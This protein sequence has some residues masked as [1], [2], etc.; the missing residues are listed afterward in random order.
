MKT[1]KTDYK[2]IDIERENRTTDNPIYW[3]KG[4]AI[5]VGIVAALFILLFFS[6]FV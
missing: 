4:F 3:V 6:S 2:W 1:D 5:I